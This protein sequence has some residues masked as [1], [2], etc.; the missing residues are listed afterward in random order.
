MFQIFKLEK[1]QT[2]YN[3]SFLNDHCT[4]SGINFAHHTPKPLI[5][6]EIFLARKSCDTIKDQ[7]GPVEQLEVRQICNHN[8]AISLS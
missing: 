3:M 5:H 8:P 7:T 4:A 1:K 2:N 6:E